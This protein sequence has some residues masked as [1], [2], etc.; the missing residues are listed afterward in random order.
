[1]R[2]MTRFTYH[3][4][5]RVFI[6]DQI[7]ET[8][9]R[10][11]A[12]WRD[13]GEENKR[14]A[15]P[16]DPAPGCPLVFLLSLFSA[17]QTKQ[18]RIPVLLLASISLCPTTNHHH[19]QPTDI[20]IQ[21][22]PVI[23]NCSDFRERAKQKV[24]TE[25]RA[26]TR[27]NAIEVE[28]LSMH[29]FESSSNRGKRCII[30]ERAAASSRSKEDA[31]PPFLLLEKS[32]ALVVIRRNLFFCADMHELPPEWVEGET[33]L[34]GWWLNE[35]LCN[36]R[37]VKDSE[38]GQNPFESHHKLWF[39]SLLWKHRDDDLCIVVIPVQVPESGLWILTDRYLFGYS[40]SVIIASESH[41]KQE[42][43]LMRMKEHKSDGRRS[44]LK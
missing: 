33:G 8:A 35:T 28:P 10:V 25:Q 4:I 5:I 14:L 27:T 38:E 22:N 37:E 21:S 29:H 31:F 42:T 23:Q 9:I 24:S 11:D 7:K 26:T 32:G 2:I 43:K 40:S 1:M 41:K 13:G 34:D 39:P 30:C 16:S 20:P 19:R 18:M 3:L 17:K 44:V 36:A 12:P 6:P 15:S